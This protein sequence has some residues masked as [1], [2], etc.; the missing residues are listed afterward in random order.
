MVGRWLRPLG[1]LA[2][3][4]L[5]VAIPKSLAAQ[6]TIA[7]RV[8][9]DDGQPLAEVRVLLVGTALS[10]VTAQDGRY[11]LRNVPLGPQVVRVLRV[12]YREQKKAATVGANAQVAVDFALAKSIVQ[13]EEIV[14]TAT[15]ARPREELG[16]AVSVINP[17]K[18][19]EESAISNLQDVLA[20]RVPG[21]TVQTGQQ[22]G[23]G[24][25]VRIRGNSSLNLSND[26]IYVID[27]IRLTSN[28]GSSSLFTGGSQPNRVNDLNPEDIENI[29]IVKGPSAATLY[30]TDAANGVIVI[31]TKRGRAGNTRWNTWAE[32]GM[33]K[34]YNDYPLNYTIYGH[35]PATPATT[36]L[37]TLNQQVIVAPA[38]APACIKDSAVSYSPLHD[39]DA[40]PIGTGYR[41]QFG[42]SAAGGNEG[43]RYFLSAER[44]EEGSQIVLPAFEKRRYA[45][46]NITPRDYNLRPNT[47][48]RYSTRGNFNATPA[49]NFD[50][51]FTTGL[52][53]SRTRFLPESNA[54]VGLG[55]QIYGGAGRKDNGNI[56]GFEAGVPSTPLTGY[57]AWTPGYTFQELLQQKLTRVITSANGDWRP[58]AW[59]QNRATVGIDY[60]SR[61]DLNLLRRGDGP[62]INSTY[63]LGFAQD[64]RTSIRNLSVDLGS[65][66]T[67]RPRDGFALRSTVGGQ[68]VDYYFEQNDATGSQL[69]TGTVTP[70]S[71]AV[72][73]ASSSTTLNKT[74]GAFIE[75]QIGYRDRLFVTGAVRSDQNSA[76][77]TKFQNVIYPKLSAAWIATDEPFFPEL[78]FLDK[79]R[80]RAAYGASGVSPGV[81]DALRSFSGTTANYRNTDVPGVLYNLVGNDKL[82]PERTSEIEVGFDAELLRR[83]N[84]E[85]TYYSKMTHDALIN[86]IIAPS[87]GSGATT[88]RKNIGSVKNAGVEA[89]LTTQVIDRRAFAADF[90]ITVAVNENKLVELGKD[91]AGNPIPPVIG[92]N[93]RA[94]AG[95]PLFGIWARPIMG[96]SDA[97]GNGII[98]ANE[99]TI[100]QDTIFRGYSTPPYSASFVPS[101]EVLDRTLKFQTLFEY[102]GGHKYYNNTER[103]RCASRQNCNGLMN[104]NA[105]LEEQAMAVAHTVHSSATLDGFYQPGGFVRWREMNVTYTLPASIATRYMKADRASL[106]FAAR[107]LHL[108]TN[109]RGLDPEIDFAAGDSG[110]FGSEF[111]TMGSPT[112]YVLRL[113]LGF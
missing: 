15:G 79:L 38:T 62:P 45:A 60:T 87:A 93:T 42:V 5:C 81:N 23:S 37:C 102:K 80:L 18:V 98:T 61:N 76:F 96:Y 95:F 99:L 53:S 4:V 41:D 113:N 14:S 22:T 3:L 112:Y 24:G 78:G 51:A 111:Q 85:L 27:G 66:A 33:L 28:S 77:G 46:Q 74:L 30:G 58:F 50:V 64:N 47:Y 52:I 83:M 100:P 43:V 110:G 17:K 109:Y 48:K 94:Y 20:A 21:V 2:A 1:V 34:D 12:G 106:N 9:S 39:P 29:E 54:T 88:V 89:L 75:E 67:Y 13:L 71:A 90:L 49:P 16:N 32:G 8:T 73:S 65:T 36:R 86:A 70:N 55:S 82:K 19:A 105:S 25:K 68:Y 101:I 7:G 6:A 108:W 40:T 44:E 57:R 91:D 11:A 59:M 56:S 10:T 84:L 35:A 97:D 63:R 104:P 107:N 31:T 103:I 72:P 69:A 26:P 92:T